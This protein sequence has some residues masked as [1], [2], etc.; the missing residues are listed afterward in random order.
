[1]NIDVFTNIGGFHKV[2]AHRTWWSVIQKNLI[3][4]SFESHIFLIIWPLSAIVLYP[5][6]T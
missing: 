4:T 5:H 2:P 1:M 3:K 6:G